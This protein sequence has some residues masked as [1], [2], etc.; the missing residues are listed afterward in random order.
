VGVCARRRKTKKQLKPKEPIEEAKDSRNW[1][2]SMRVPVR[3][4]AL[5]H[6][7]SRFNPR[8]VHFPNYTMASTSWTAQRVRETFLDYFKQNG[9]TF[10]E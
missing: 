10:G 9:H 6:I 1:G 3:N 8:L 2:S 4:G 5:T 7:F